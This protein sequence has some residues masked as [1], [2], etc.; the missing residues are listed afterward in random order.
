VSRSFSKSQK[1]SLL[2]SSDFKCCYC[3]CHL[4]W[5]NFH[6]DHILPY[7]K[8]GMTTLKNGQALC[9]SCNL[10][11]GNK[12]MSIKLLP[13]QEKCRTAYV[14]HTAKDFVLVAGTGTGKTICASE[15]A[16]HTYVAGGKKALIFVVV[17]YRTIKQGWA[18]AFER[19]GLGVA[20]NYD[21]YAADTQ[22]VVTTYAG[23]KNMIDSITPSLMKID[24]KIILIFD[25]FHHLEEENTWANPFLTMCETLY[26]KRIFL[27]G[28]PW[29]E[30]GIISDSMV[31]YDADDKVVADFT[32]T[33][34][35]NV[36]GND[37][38][39]NTVEVVFKPTHI[40]KS[41][42]RTNTETGEVETFHFDSEQVD[43]KS[44]ITRFVSITSL[45]ELARDTGLMELLSQSV[46]EL[47]RIK[48]TEMAKA[49]GIV[50]VSTKISGEAV[51]AI[52]RSEFGKSATL[53]TSDDPKAQANIDSFSNSTD[54]WIV[55]IDMIA[56]GTDIPRL[57]VVC[58]LANKLTMMHIIQR[59][60]RVLRM[61]RDS[62]GNPE[63]NTEARIFFIN[64]PKLVYAAT[65]IETEVALAK[66]EKKEKEAEQDDVPEPP[67][68]P[69]YEYVL[70]D[71]DQNGKNHIFKGDSLELEQTNLTSWI[72]ETNYND[73]KSTAN[74]ED[75]VYKYALNM[76]KFMVN[77]Q[78]I[79]S[80]YA[81]RKEVVPEPISTPTISLEDRK[82]EVIKRCTKLIGE[83]TQRYYDNDYRASGKLIN[84]KLGKWV[85]KNKTLVEMEEREENLKIIITEL[86]QGLHTHSFGHNTRM[87]QTISM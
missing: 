71:V 78:A 83:V 76:S 65:E 43:I 2:L 32:Y 87:T 24:K 15:L 64:H 1:L 22:V 28:T 29:H 42:N 34:G 59:W 31:K 3:K 70:V 41:V 44:P 26:V 11:K 7:S 73:I 6:A 56:E 5:Q 8:G 53:V 62:R 61:L 72:I 50:F 36:N 38:E 80:E 20:T 40:K 57:K 66:N 46:H 33:Y 30:S 9:V 63:K 18:K 68:A 55:A 60:G 86:K 13:W 75:S 51:C 10:Q 47:E 74:N 45:L 49:G 77:M 67:P 39:K 17:P 19:Q 79:P 27:S 54:D 14:K 23:A 35:T 52:L 58:D 25:E 69:E 16:K 37:D 48:T 84:G 12:D 4:H 85:R 81:V 21:N 82:K